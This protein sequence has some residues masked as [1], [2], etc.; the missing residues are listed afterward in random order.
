LLAQLAPLAGEPEPVARVQDTRI[1][2]TPE[3]PVRVYIP[4]TASAPPVVLYFHG[5]GWVGGDYAHI[6]T[7]VRALANRSGCA[8]VSVNYRL[9][10]EHK[11]PAAIDDAY[12]ALT[13]AANESGRFG[14]DGSRL[15]VA[16]DSAGGNLA[17]AAA[18]RA[19][20]DQGPAVAFQLLIYPVLDHDYDNESYRSFGTSW[21]VITRTDMMW[22]HC[23]YVSHPDQLDQPYVSPVRC[24]DLTGLPQALIIVP[25]ADPLRD[26]ALLYGKR[27]QEAGVPAAAKVVAG[28][29][30]GFW[31]L[32]ALM[33]E[34]RTCLEDAAQALRSCFFVRA[35]VTAG[36]G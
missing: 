27:L 23:Q 7:P 33:P 11:Y 12:A 2:G 25:E 30:H 16:G 32:G 24:R 21:G 36:A 29:I 18:L 22:F 10:P 19:R 1:P 8:I 31:Q 13:W 3:I 20:D 34:A 5:G 28:S 6:D 4:D 15:A 9:A 17:A 35:G 26:E 14:W